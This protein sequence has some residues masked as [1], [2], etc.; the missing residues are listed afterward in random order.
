[1]KSLWI[2][3]DI[4]T[5][6]ISS[7]ETHGTY[8]V[9]EIEAAPNN[10]PPL[11]KHSMEDEG[12]YV[13]EGVF[14]FLYGSEETK[15]GNGQFMYVP[16]DEFHTYK[17]IGSSFG[18]LLLIISPPQFEKF[19]EEIGIPINNKSSFQPPQ[20][21]PA[22]IENVVKTAARYGLEIKI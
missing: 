21:T 1:M 10:G 4:Y 22:I 2:L 5:V 13:L 12:F 17:N 15:A 6:K 16:R 20:I 14:S 3:G 11:H 8:S 18:K 9:W 7:D 19:F